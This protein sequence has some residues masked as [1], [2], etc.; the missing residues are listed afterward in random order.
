MALGEAG[1]IVNAQLYKLIVV[2]ESGD[3]PSAGDQEIK[4]LHD[5]VW[6]LPHPRD[7]TTTRSEPVYSH[8]WRDRTLEA[9]A[10]VTADLAEYLEELSDINDRGA[11]PSRTWKIDAKNVGTVAGDDIAETFKAKVESYQH[12]APEAG[13]VHVRF[14]LLAEGESK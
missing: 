2:A 14:T 10:V 9:E 12:V 1:K 11:L 6:S 3:T 13:Q 5:A 4:L 7:R 8:Q